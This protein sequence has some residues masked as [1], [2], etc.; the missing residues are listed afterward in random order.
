MH[1]SAFRF[2]ALRF[3]TS[4][5]RSTASDVRFSREENQSCVVR[6]FRGRLLLPGLLLVLPA[7][8]RAQTN[9]F[10]ASGSVGVGTPTPGAPLEVFSTTGGYTAFITGGGTS[11]TR[12]ALRNE[13]DQ[14]QVELDI[15]GGS[16]PYALIQA[17]KTANIGLQFSAAS[18]AFL[19]GSFGIGTSSLPS[20]GK[21]Q[22]N[23]IVDSIAVNSSGAFRV[24][25]GTNFA[26]GVGSD[27]WAHN[28]ANTD[29]TV[30]TPNNLYLSAGSAKRVSI[31]A[32]GNVGIGTNNPA[33]LLTVGAASVF[34]G[35]A[36][37]GKFNIQG[38]AL[39]TT[40]GSSIKIG[41]FSFDTGGNHA[42]LGISATRVS[43]GSDWT[44]TGVKFQFDVD[45]TNPVADKILTFTSS[46]NVGI[47][48]SLPVS[49]LSIAGR[50][51]VGAGGFSGNNGMTGV[52]LNGQAGA[53]GTA[54]QGILFGGNGVAHGNLAWLPNERTFIFR[55]GI[56]P[57]DIG[58]SYGAATIAT[59]GTLRSASWQ[60]YGSAS[61]DAYLDVEPNTR[62]FRTRNWNTA[63]PNIAATGLHTGAGIFDGNVGIG[64]TTPAERLHIMNGAVRADLSTSGASGIFTGSGS[65]LHI[66][67]NGTAD[68]R[69]LNSSGGGY[70][71]VN[72]T[73]TVEMVTVAG[74]GK[75]GIG[76][77]APTR[78]LDVYGT[79]GWT[80]S[81][82][83]RLQGNNPGIEMVDLAS[84]QR[85]LMANG[86]VTGYDGKL[87]LAYDVNRGRHNIVVDTAGHVGVG[88]LA[89][90]ATLDV[91]GD[92]KVSG[93]L[94]VNGTLSAPNYTASSGVVSGGLAGLVLNAGGTNQSVTITPSGTGATI[95]NGTV[96]IGTNVPSGKLTV[97]RNDNALGTTGAPGLWLENI[98]AGDSG[99]TFK[100][101]GQLIGGEWQVFQSNDSNKF[102]IG[103][104]AVADY[105][106]I[107]TGG[108]VGI[109]TSAPG[110]YKLAVNGT[111]HAKEVV[112]DQIGWADYVFDENYRNAPLS[113]VER[114]IK[115]HKH[116]PGV[117][118]ASEVAEKGV[119]VGQMQ[120]VLLQKIEE[121]TLH[122]IEQEKEMK[123]LRGENVELK[124]RM[125]QLESTQK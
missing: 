4:E 100:R 125:A 32:N 9:V 114:H 79:G 97:T 65:N 108:N 118:S 104:A 90:T 61:G 80:S 72:S 36:F 94:A 92:A 31:L 47:G 38:G 19:N 22:V 49:K 117:P 123:A 91:A 82:G 43:T 110:S 96:G 52:V 24:F 69:F 29:F 73:N 101:A 40:V 95:L 55:T 112:V 56:N 99:L 75:V 39:G 68:V 64:T 5:F 87:G 89:P 51:D 105:V 18:Y 66:V 86:V 81:G 10:P 3:L 62:M 122:V 21:L 102:K 113:E 12:F 33:S 76:V 98:G 27:A 115:E 74:D 54:S 26:G 124:A 119:S 20:N 25:D 77:A 23:G 48:T 44:T 2:T 58:D 67:H 107:E 78:Q 93:N 50:L 85:W 13:T 71:F 1:R 17:G 42:G 14:G 16:N 11:V 34:P 60:P 59:N 84:S 70:K 88:T 121:L 103:R 53:T 41:D 6:L 45:K 120:T 8:V 116:L 7:L 28:C 15:A 106:T 30:F 46:G 111:V 37:D 35:Y 63:S 57:T 83:I 109:G